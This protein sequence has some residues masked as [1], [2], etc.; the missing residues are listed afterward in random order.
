MVFR[1][2]VP[3]P[4]IEPVSP[5]L[6]VQ[7]PNHWTV[8]PLRSYSVIFGK[9]WGAF[10]LPR[11]RVLHCPTHH[12]LRYLEAV[13]GGQLGL[14]GSQ[15]FTPVGRSCPDLTGLVC[16]LGQGGKGGSSPGARSSEVGASGASKGLC[17]P[18]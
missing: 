18:R 2:L 5:A 9:L 15:F 13:G 6:E 10:W 8:G 1:V 3:L 11:S 17:L 16:S 7:S 4:G 14:G 12:P